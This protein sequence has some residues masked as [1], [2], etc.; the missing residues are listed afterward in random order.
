MNQ[1]V[2]FIYC[3]D[4]ELYADTRKDRINIALKQF[5]KQET[6]NNRITTAKK[7]LNSVQFARIRAKYEHIWLEIDVSIKE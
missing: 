4:K 5:D 7:R 1:D 2:F 6:G 3:N